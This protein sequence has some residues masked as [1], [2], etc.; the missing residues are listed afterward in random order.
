MEEVFHFYINYPPKS[1]NLCSEIQ[2]PEQAISN[3]GNAN[4]E[5][6]NTQHRELKLDNMHIVQCIVECITLEVEV[7]QG[8]QIHSV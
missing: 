3:P 8:K 1:L 6:K 7:P 4:L 2:T 5:F